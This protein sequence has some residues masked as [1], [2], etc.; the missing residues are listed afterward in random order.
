MPIERKLA[1]IMFTD[2][3]GFTKIMGDDEDEALHILRR[4]K[5][6]I[7]PIITDFEGNILKF[8]G[9]GILIEFKSGVEAVQCAMKV[10]DMIKT[11]NK[12]LP[13]QQ[14]INLRIGIH[15]GDV[16]VVENDIYGD[17]VNIASRL[18]PFA[19]P[20]GICISQSVY[21]VVKNRVEVQTVSLGKKQLK[22]IKMAVSIYKVVV[23]AQGTGGENVEEKIEEIQIIKA[24]GKDKSIMK[25]IWYVGGFIII[26]LLLFFQKDIKSWFT[27]TKYPVRLEFLGSHINAFSNDSEIVWTYMLDNDVV[28][29]VE[30][31][32]I[33]KYEIV[34]IDSDGK[35]EIIAGIETT[36][37]ARKRYHVYCFSPNGE[38]LWK[39]KVGRR[40]TWGEDNIKEDNFHLNSIII[41]D[42][43][44]D[45]FSEI[46]I[47]SNH[48]LYF[49]AFLN[50]FA[51]D[52]EKIG[53]WLNW[54]RIFDI[55][56]H[57]LDRDGINE[58]LVGGTL[59]ITPGKGGFISVFS[60]DNIHGQDPFHGC[61]EFS[62]GTEKYYIVFPRVSFANVRRGE[63]MKVEI[64][65]E[66]IFITIIDGV[67]IPGSAFNRLTYIYSFDFNFNLISAHFNDPTIVFIEQYIIQN[68]LSTTLQDELELLNQI[69]Y[70]NGEEFKNKVCINK[71]WIETEH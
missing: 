52:G 56:I 22:N 9:D 67:T 10:Q 16:V 69:V 44:H 31:K 14:K 30:K 33:V 25:P 12:G 71:N 45:G 37:E 18:Q 13:E 28:L 57:D 66:K 17:G 48:N 8:M 65:N 23:D 2:I 51:H 58:I 21:D 53:E 32:P 49:P 11:Y 1:A 40:T 19:E 26:L 6:I 43:N 62:A 24:L 38:L 29:N 36:A 4:H 54:G 27:D 7:L 42:V 50:V 5:E 64:V 63:V 34:D 41:N 68:D 20:G 39:K 47:V 46:L 55:N 35:K 59:N 3:V 70:W 15:I 60:Y 61:N